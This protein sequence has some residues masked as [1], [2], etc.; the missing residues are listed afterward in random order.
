MSN[1]NPLGVA[2]RE[3]IK[4][5]GE[6]NK[7]VMRNVTPGNC[8]FSSSCFDCFRSFLGN[9]IVFRS[10]KLCINLN[11]KTIIGPI[12]DNMINLIDEIWGSDIFNGSSDNTIP[13]FSKTILII[14]NMMSSPG[15]TD[16]NVSGELVIIIE[17]DK[18]L[19]RNAKSPNLSTPLKSS[20]QL[21]VFSNFV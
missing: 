15:T 5:N 2:I 7:K 3:I 11:A 20:E 16:E 6:I 14:G 10:C 18:K 12:D 19:I 1:T 21:N 9:F 4:I 13:I 8:L 17:I